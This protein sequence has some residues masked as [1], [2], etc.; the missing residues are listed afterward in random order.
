LFA[1]EDYGRLMIA[2]IYVDGYKKIIELDLLKFVGGLICFYPP[3]I[4]ASSGFS[5]CKKFC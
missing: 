4:W 1:K 3:V 5:P 2:Q